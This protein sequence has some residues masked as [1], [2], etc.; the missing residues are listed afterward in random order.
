MHDIVL[1][2]SFQE[3]SAFASQEGLKGIFHVTN[4]DRIKGLRPRRIHVLPSYSARRDK[5]AVNAVVATMQRQNRELQLIDY[6]L[7]KTEEGK[8]WVPA[9]DAEAAREA[10]RAAHEAKERE[11]IEAKRKAA[12]AAK[13]EKP[14]RQPKAK[15]PEKPALGDPTPPSALAAEPLNP[16]PATDD[17]FGDF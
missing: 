5:H 10:A 15:G 17:A 13:S 16:A 1:S 12:A 7:V 14:K 6:D 8:R 2:N 9:A 11:A 3:T 4:R